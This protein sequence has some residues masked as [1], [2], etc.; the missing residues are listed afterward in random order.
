MSSLPLY[1]L[2]LRAADERRRLQSSMTELKSRVRENLDLTKT[3]RKHVWWAGA[4]L[5]VVGL[6]SGYAIT[7]LFTHH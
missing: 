3:A 2:E 6:L 5:A 4:S 1:Q 7:G